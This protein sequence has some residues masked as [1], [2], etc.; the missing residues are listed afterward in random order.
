MQ[1]STLAKLRVC[2]RA[3]AR[4]CVCSCSTWTWRRST[5]HH[6]STV[7]VSAFV[8]TPWTSLSTRCPNPES[9]FAGQSLSPT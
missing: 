1:K 4:V 7:T 8:S 5:G 2:V 3:R 6:I 9:F